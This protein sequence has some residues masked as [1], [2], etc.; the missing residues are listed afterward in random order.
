MNRQKNNSTRCYTQSSPST[1]VR[2]TL[3]IDIVN[4]IAT[5][6]HQTGFYENW[7]MQ[8]FQSVHGF[9]YLNNRRRKGKGKIDRVSVI[10]NPSTGQQI[11]LPKLGVRNCHSKSF[12]GYDPIEK[13]FK[14]LCITSFKEHHVLRL[15]T[16]GEHLWRKIECSFPHYPL[17]RTYA[18]CTNGVLYYKNSKNTIVCFDVRYETFS[19]IEI[20]IYVNVLC[21][22]NYKGK[23]GLLVVFPNTGLAQLWV[24]DDTKKVE[25][26]KH[27]FVFPDTTFEAIRLTDRGE[28][29]GASNRSTA[30]FYVSYYNMEKESVERV[31]IK[32]IEDKVSMHY[33]GPYE[34]FIFPNHVENVMFLK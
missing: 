4:V 33:P 20:K 32:G 28:I 30:P 26:S 10:W 19:F 27:R 12:L 31:K 23:L 9:I 29:F 22:I 15:G 34:F 24:L 1:Y 18:I 21:L 2:E 17:K 16:G 8:S 25:W 3:P 6:Y 11:P 14:V 13:Q 7:C 5:D